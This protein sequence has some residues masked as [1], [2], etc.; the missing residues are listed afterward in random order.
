[1]V[2]PSE[3]EGYGLVVVEA[4]ARGTPSVVVRAPD[5]AAVELVDD[6]VNGVVAESAAPERPGRGDPARA[7]RGAGTPRR[8][9]DWFARHAARLSLDSSLEQRRP[10]RTGATAPAPVGYLAR[11]FVETEDEN[12]AAIL[13]ALLP[14]P[15]A[16]LVDL[17]CGDGVLHR[18]GGAR[19]SERP[20]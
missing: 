12:R 15:D 13:A 4:S 1:M 5:N 8:T 14:K 17:G 19:A 20:R 6:G 18:G 16:V 7:R 9:C 10:Q 3:R 11:N 2:L